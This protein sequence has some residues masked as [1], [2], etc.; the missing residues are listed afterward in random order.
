MHSVKYNATVAQINHNRVKEVTSSALAVRIHI[1]IVQQ[2]DHTKT[3]FHTSSSHL[4][5]SLSQ[6]IWVES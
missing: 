3:L 4:K 2:T 5:M 1:G 6:R